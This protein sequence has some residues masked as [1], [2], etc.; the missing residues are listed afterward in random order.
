[1]NDT[2]SLRLIDAAERMVIFLDKGYETT[3]KLEG[4]NA[5]RVVWLVAIAG[6]A[7]INLPTIVKGGQFPPTIIAPWALVAL[8]GVITHWLHRAV[9]IQNFSMY[10]VKR[11][12]LLTLIINGPE[13]A[14]LDA[15]R[16]ILENKTPA[17]QP[18][19]KSLNR[20]TTAASIMEFA[21]FAL[22]VI[23]IGFVIYWVFLS[24]QS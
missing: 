8:F 9:A 12:Q 11:E 1:M 6:F 23:S 10:S 19:A 4:A 18:V 20:A 16:Q 24:R 15:L 2:L 3:Q 14:T 13:L 22:F 21:T 5:S 17:L 7:I